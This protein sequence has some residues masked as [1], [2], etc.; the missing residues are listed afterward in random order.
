MNKK[1][2]GAAAA[3]S[4]LTL[5]LSFTGCAKKEAPS[6]SSDKG[7]G[8]ITLT[9]WESL[10]GPDEFIKQ[11]GEA[12]TKTHPNVKIEFVNVEVGDAAGQIALDGPAGKGPDLFAAPH[13]KLGE[14][15]TSG[16]VKPTVNAEEVKKEV[17]GACSQ[18]LT[19]EGQM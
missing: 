10:S 5:G 11:A 2:V 12:Y 8:T 16:H 14:M 1:I 9:V 13:D 15:V 18:A 7:N 4:A 6:S 19:Y 3:L 17:L